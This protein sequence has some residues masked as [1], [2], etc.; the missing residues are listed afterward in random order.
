LIGLLIG[1]EL[2]KTSKKAT[3][4]KIE[5]IKRETEIKISDAEDSLRAK[6]IKFMEKHPLVAQRN[7]WVPPPT[8]SA[9]P[10][11]TMP[12]EV[13]VSEYCPRC[14]SKLP[15]PFQ[16]SNRFKLLSREVLAIA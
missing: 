5:K 7:E 3:E 1:A 16:A 2:D 6:L 13:L 8:I 12:E 15:P 4:R 9:M 11:T 10:T 14:D